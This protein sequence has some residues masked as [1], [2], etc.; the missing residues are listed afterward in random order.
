[1]FHL[2][3][4]CTIA[5]QG[6]LQKIIWCNSRLPCLALSHTHT[7]IMHENMTSR[8]N[9]TL[10]NVCCGVVFLIVKTYIFFFNSKDG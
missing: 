2:K 7:V 1:M 8:I 6:I 10:T 5:S 4:N 9:V 3:K